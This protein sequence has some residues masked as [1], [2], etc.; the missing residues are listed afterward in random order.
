MTDIVAIE[1]KLADVRYQI[2]SMESQLR[3]Y[4]N[5]IRYSTVNLT[6][7]E[8]EKTTP[9]APKDTWGR[10]QTGFMEDLSRV[11]HGLQNVGIWILTHIPSLVV[12]AI[13]VVIVVVLIKKYHKGSGKR[14]QR[15][16]E[17]ERRE[18]EKRAERR[19]KNAEKKNGIPAAEPTHT[20]VTDGP[21]T[22][23]DD[24]DKGETGD[25]NGT[26]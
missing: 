20:E 26:K 14:A 1:D 24:A 22:G 25:N 21:E 15:R 6:I 8:V 7:D 12:W 10:I 18:A 17:K 23:K 13:V 5:Q 16:A 4:E 11:L 9:K 19:R 2:E 3:T